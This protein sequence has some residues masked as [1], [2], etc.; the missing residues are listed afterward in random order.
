MVYFN[1][2]CEFFFWVFVGEETS[3]E[4]DTVKVTAKKTTKSDLSCGGSLG[5]S[6]QFSDEAK[7]SVPTE[8]VNCITSEYV[9]EKIFERKNKSFMSCNW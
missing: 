8:S 4:T 9:S 1:S 2:E 5:N 3:I 7:K 6:I